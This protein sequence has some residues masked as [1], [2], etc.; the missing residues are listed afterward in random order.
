M[1]KS[2]VLKML[3]EEHHR[4]LSETSEK[5][6]TLTHRAVGILTIITGWLILAGQVPSGVLRWVLIAG[7]T[8][9]VLATCV[10]LLRYNRNYR[11]IAS[12]VAK[13]NSAFG[14]FESGRYLPD[15]KMYPDRW[16]KFGSEPRLS[17]IWHHLTIICLMSAVC[18]T[19]ALVR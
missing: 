18:I 9:I 17:G 7:I 19:A 3:F 5:I 6:R 14:F 15:D 16:A 12:V 8:V 10:T 13:I 1:E 11:T 2:E 4:Q